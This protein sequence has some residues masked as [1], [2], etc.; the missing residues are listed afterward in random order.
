[1]T[2]SPKS[3]VR[4]RHCLSAAPKPAFPTKSSAPKS[5]SSSFFMFF[6]SRSRFCRRLISVSAGHG[7]RGFN[8]SDL[9]L[10]NLPG[11][12]YKADVGL[13]S[14]LSAII[15]APS[16]LNCSKSA[17]GASRHTGAHR[18]AATSA[19]SASYRRAEQNCT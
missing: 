4:P 9:G 7:C 18:G 13:D 10:L 3:D 5:S 11:S 12:I 15:Y 19:N 14:T 2:S 1:M 8:R 6:S 16:P 17:N